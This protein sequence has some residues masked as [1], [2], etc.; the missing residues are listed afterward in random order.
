M[1]YRQGEVGCRSVGYHYATNIFFAVALI[2][3]INPPVAPAINPHF[4]A[5]VT[6]RFQN[7]AAKDDNSALRI[8][9]APRVKSVRLNMRDKSGVERGYIG[10]Y[11]VDRFVNSDKTGGVPGAFY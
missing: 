7:I 4:K 9:L 11:G 10:R 6:P 1:Q 5:F 3:D 2:D 8:H